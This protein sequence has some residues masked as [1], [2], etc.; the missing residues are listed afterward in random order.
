MMPD[1]PPWRQAPAAIDALI[2]RPHAERP[3]DDR[4]RVCRRI[5]GGN[6]TGSG[7]SKPGGELKTADHERRHRLRSRVDDGPLESS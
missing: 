4:D 5:H 2:T 1:R 7:K 6:T 3:C